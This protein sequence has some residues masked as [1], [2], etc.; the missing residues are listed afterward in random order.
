MSKGKGFLDNLELSLKSAPEK[1]EQSGEPEFKLRK[2]TL[3]IPEELDE[4]LERASFWAH[5]YKNYYLS[6]VL[7]A[8][9]GD[10]IFKPIPEHLRPR[11]RGR[12][13]TR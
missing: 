1:K 9:F 3:E 10:E 8:H 2:I 13:K 6:K 7:E 5:Q 11:P 4:K 12:K